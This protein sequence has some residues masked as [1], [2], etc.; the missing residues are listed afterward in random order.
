MEGGKN[1]LILERSLY[2]ACSRR[3]GEESRLGRP[4][5]LLRAWSIMMA[6]FQKIV[7]KRTWII[8]VQ[9]NDV[10][11]EKYCSFLEGLQTKQCYQSCTYGI[12]P[13]YFRPCAKFSDTVRHSYKVS[14]LIA[15]CLQWVLGASLTRWIF[16]R[17]KDHE[18]VSALTIKS[19]AVSSTLPT[20]SSRF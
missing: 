10:P 17:W 1:T 4:E 7:Q 16:L 13:L 18:K 19:Y 15:N 8:Q 3:S 6:N 20:S 2:L 12:I 5:S 9:R 14:S 11:D